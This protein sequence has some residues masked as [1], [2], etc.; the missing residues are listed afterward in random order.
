MDNKLAEEA[1]T[2]ALF[3]DFGLPVMFVTARQTMGQ[4]LECSDLDA[5]DRLER[6]RAIFRLDHA[7]F[8][9]AI[10]QK[11]ELP[12]LFVDAVGHHHS[13][14]DLAQT[15]GQKAILEACYVAGLFPHILNAWNRQ[16]AEEMERFLHE[17]RPD[18]S[19]K[20][21]LDT[22]QKEF[23][24]L[25]TYFEPDDAPEIDLRTLLEAAT[26]EAADNTTRLVGV[27]QQMM[28]QMM[29]AGR[30]S[31]PAAVASIPSPSLTRPR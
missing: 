17:H 18:L 7:E 5:Q 4:L 9:R 10:A 24:Q 16:D 6:E 11:L 30:S 14:S 28:Q 26:A 13:Y 25:Y 19:A 22:V 3:Q 8:G 23:V 31:K 2:A 29:G 1:F 15:V 20:A 12:E 21:F 27:V